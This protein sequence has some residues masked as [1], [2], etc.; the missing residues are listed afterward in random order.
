ME[1]NM[2]NLMLVSYGM[3]V[4]TFGG[5]ISDGE[6]DTLE[7]AFGVDGQ[8]GVCLGFIH[9]Q[10]YFTETLDRGSY[11]ISTKLHNKI[12]AYLRDHSDVSF[13]VI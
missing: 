13:S 8:S 4:T 7:N 10:T 12:F 1:V 6:A 3:R 5:R 11:R 2:K 9:D